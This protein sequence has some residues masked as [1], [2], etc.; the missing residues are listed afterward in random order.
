MNAVTAMSTKGQVVIPKDVRDA[1]AIVPGQR[2]HVSTEGGDIVL[3]RHITEDDKRATLEILADLHARFP[4][5]GPAV[6]I[7]EMNATIDEAWAE[8]ALQSNC[9]P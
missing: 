9:L 7:D 3:R 1:L 6:S 2:F 4:Y 8:S 5:R